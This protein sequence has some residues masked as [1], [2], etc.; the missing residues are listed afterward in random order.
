M[1]TH[2]ASLTGRRTLAALALQL[3][4]GLGQHALVRL[5]QAFDTPDAVVHASVRAWLNAGVRVSPG[6]VPGLYTDT[7]LR[8]AALLQR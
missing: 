7:V 3:T 5:V 2:I 4:P 1:N 8:A 6:A